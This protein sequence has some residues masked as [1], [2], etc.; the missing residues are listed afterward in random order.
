MTNP[1]YRRFDVISSDF[2]RGLV[3]GDENDRAATRDPF[4]V[5][6]YIAAKRL[7][8]GCLT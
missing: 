2:C 3:S 7:A 1:A 4:D 8:A 6:R 5:L